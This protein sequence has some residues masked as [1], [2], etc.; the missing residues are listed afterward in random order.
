M[1]TDTWA[2][3]L[4]LMGGDSDRAAQA[5]DPVAWAEGNGVELWSKQREVM[6]SV[7]DNRRTV[8]RAGHGVSKSFTA[9][10]L[11]AWWVARYPVGEALVV[12]TAP[13]QA[14]VS[15]ILWGELRRLHGR[16]GLPGTIGLDN[17]WKIGGQIVAIGRKP[18]DSDEVA[19]QGLHAR[20]VLAILDEAAGLPD[21]LW[22]AVAGVVTSET[23]RTL[24]IGNPDSRGGRFEKCFEPG[25]GWEPIHVPVT[26]S[27]AFT[28]EVVSADLL[29]VLPSQSWVDDA[30]RSWGENSPQYVSRVLGEF[31]AADVDALVT[32]EQIKAGQQFTWPGSLYPVI[33]G[34]DVARFGNDSTVIAIRNGWSV[35]VMQSYRGEPTTYTAGVLT[36]LSRR[37]GNVPVHVDDT[38]LG[39]GVTDLLRENGVRVEAIIAAA[40]AS[41]SKQFA[42]A[43]AEGYWR[44]RQA[45][46]VG[47]LDLDPADDELAKQLARLR[48]KLDSRGR[49]L[50]ESKDVMRSRGEPSPDRADAIALAFTPPP[51][52]RLGTSY[53]SDLG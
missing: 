45:L 48:Y 5:A 6:G 31:P 13:T 15:A 42:N 41:D 21:P 32:W 36:N 16:L 46:E 19:F 11:A 50:I 4:D 17:V 14:Q 24:A 12:T 3:L 9:S 47:L 34:C 51:G 39:G 18:A 49:V 22:D 10:L 53:G 30:R 23:S 33:I 29:A 43:R 25:S 26:Q 28:G 8:V 40:Q 38:G 35:R 7:R 52:P 2:Q 27:P 20:H 37:L 1:T 44:V